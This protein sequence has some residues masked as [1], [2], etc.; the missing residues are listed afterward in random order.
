[1]NV[2]LRPRVIVGVDESMAGLR[3]LR[4][5]VEEARR[6][7]ASL[8]AV[9]AWTAP[10]TWG[11]VGVPVWRQEMTAGAVE[12][13]RRAFDEALGGLPRDLTVVLVTGEGPAGPVLSR[14]AY[15]DSDLLVVG[16]R[17]PGLL[18]RV[19]RLL[20][21]S[22]ARHCLAHAGCPVLVI[23]PD[24]F[25]RTAGRRGAGRELGRELSELTAAAPAER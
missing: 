20:R 2:T 7:G 5:A 8:H 17:R 14:H 3:A 12:E 23:P 6:R 16:A 22:I 24:S 13:I 21:P 1:M 4:V 11:G 10:A 9:R 15:R 18:G 19:G 25:A